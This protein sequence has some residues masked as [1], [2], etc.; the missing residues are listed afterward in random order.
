MRDARDSLVEVFAY[1]SKTLPRRTAILH[2][3]YA[4]SAAAKAAKPSQPR[5]ELPVSVAGSVSAIAATTSTKTSA[6]GLTGPA[7]I[8]RAPS[9]PAR[10]P[11]RASDAGRRRDGWGP[12]RRTARCPRDRAAR[13]APR[14]PRPRSAGPDRGTGVPS[15]RRRRRQAPSHG[16][17]AGRRAVQAGRLRPVRT[18]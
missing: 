3:T 11:G 16:W 15:P 14:W 7:L 13:R 10:G 18:R 8:G 12:R 5:T 9:R 2:R 4:T 17:V 1:R 6:R